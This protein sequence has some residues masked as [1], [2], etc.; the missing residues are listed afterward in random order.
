MTK[1]NFWVCTSCKTSYDVLHNQVQKVSIP[2]HGQLFRNSE[3]ILQLEI[4]RDGGYFMIGI[5]KRC[6]GW[7]GV[8]HCR[9]RISQ[10]SVK[11]VF[12]ENAYFMALIRSQ[13]KQKLTTLLA[14]V[15]TD[16]NIAAS[17]FFFLSS[18]QPHKLFCSFCFFLV[19]QL[20]FWLRIIEAYGIGSNCWPRRLKFK[21]MK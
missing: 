6:G 8:L 20:V 18:K 1:A 7:G 14:T 17:S 2:Y 19:R 13:I 10:G 21:M 4:K 11:S 15:E 3:G 5:F 16:L 12:L 9:S